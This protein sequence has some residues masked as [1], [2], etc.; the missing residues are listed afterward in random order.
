MLIDYE[1]YFI[2][3]ITLIEILQ[4]KHLPCSN[5]SQEFIP[6]R[7]K[8]LWISTSVQGAEGRLHV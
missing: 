7:A 3:I 5:S 6:K 4:Q 1:K 8:D 2:L